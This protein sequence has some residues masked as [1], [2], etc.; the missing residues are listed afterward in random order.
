MEL[1]GDA[2]E[3][4]AGDGVVDLTET[5]V[6]VVVDLFE[7]RGHVSRALVKEAKESRM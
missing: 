6:G 7:L 1:N 2:L 5:G 3:R 4:V